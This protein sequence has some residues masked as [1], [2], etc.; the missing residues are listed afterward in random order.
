MY[1]ILVAE[2]RSERGQTAIDGLADLRADITGDRRVCLARLDG[3]ID[4]SHPSLAD[5]SR[6]RSVTIAITED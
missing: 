6:H 3:P 5:S 1:C 2:S 4:L